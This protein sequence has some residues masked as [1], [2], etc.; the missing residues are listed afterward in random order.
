MLQVAGIT[1]FNPVAMGRGRDHE[2]ACKEESILLDNITGWPWEGSNG[3]YHAAD[4]FFRPFETDWS[5][6]N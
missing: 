6:I 4:F 3:S 5:L 2:T 1:L